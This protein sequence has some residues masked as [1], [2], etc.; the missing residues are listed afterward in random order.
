MKNYNTHN[1]T[2]IITLAILLLV[3]AITSAGGKQSGK[4]TSAHANSTNQIIVKP[5][6]TG[7]LSIAARPTMSTLKS[8][9]ESIQMQFDYRRSTGTGAW[10]LRLPKNM[11]LTAAQAI[12][13]RLATDPSIEYAMADQRMYPMAVP[14]DTSYV[15]QWHY[16]AAAIESGAA[17]LPS[18]WDVTL[19]SNSVVVAV[20]DTGLLP[21]ADID[22]NLLDNTG[23]VTNGYDFVSEDAAGQYYTANDGNGRDADPTDPGDWINAA[24]SAGVDASGGLFAG[25]PQGD[26]TWHGTHVS[27]TIAASSNNNTGVAGIL[28]SGR[29]MPV[30]VLGKC[31]GYSSDIIDGVLWAAGL[32]PADG[33]ADFPAPPLTPAKV[34]NMSF[35]GLSPICPSEWQ[36]LINSVVAAGTTIVVAAGNDGINASGST[37]ANCNNVIAVGAHRR[38]GGQASYSN[39]GSKVD[40]SAPGGD[41]PVNPDGILSLSNFGITNA[42]TDTY[43]YY[44][45]TSMASPHVSGVAGLMLSINSDITP[46]QI[47]SIIKTN[48]RP[49][50]TGTGSDCT[51]A[52]CGDGMLDASL[53]VNAVT[54]TLIADTSDIYFSE[55]WT[56]LSATPR[57]ITFTNTH[58]TTT[59]N[60]GSVSVAGVNAG[61][62][63]LP[64]DACSGQALAAG[65]SCDIDV[66]FSPATSGNHQAMITVSSDAPSNPEIGLNGDAGPTITITATD[67][68]AAE[69]AANTA[70]F[71][72]NSSLTVPAGGLVV[73]YT[74]A[75]TATSGSDYTALSGSATLTAG[76]T[77]TDV[78]LTP[79]DDAT[80]EN[81]ENIT[82]SLSSATSYVIGSPA[83][84]T[85]YLVSDDGPTVTITATDNL[86]A[87][88]GT[89][90]AIFSI[91]SNQ[92]A[93][94]GGLTVN[95]TVSGT[96]VSGSD[97]TPISGSATIPGGAT[98]TSV[99]ITPRNDTIFELTESVDLAISNSTNYMTGSPS[100]ASISIK[101]ND[102]MIPPSSGGGGC[103]IA[104]ASY[105][106]LMAPEINVLRHFR[107]EYLLTNIPG[108]WFVA[109][110]YKLSPPIADELRK[111]PTLRALMRASLAPLV[112]VSNWLEQ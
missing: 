63:L 111:H 8:L 65:A 39:Y 7:R 73:N 9:S 86:A 11:S 6:D 59:Y 109:A 27:G 32:L 30:R 83:N 46:A 5:E 57:T 40:I 24:E 4:L 20:I 79:I 104:T 108:Q 76:T 92:A 37:P 69:A 43:G 81:M 64:S 85:A 106:T 18:A 36:S 49:F 45:G 55:I 70:T 14:N 103:F 54:G 44:S 58:K 107:D 99:I 41:T 60:I 89:D 1:T 80:I 48:S 105:G 101:D 74:V 23:I 10:V 3:P 25:C 91:D 100:F 88:P 61:S 112:A 34:I 96:A 97:Y 26:S 110:Y 31:F 13:D 56:G 90:T 15:S 28:W 50:V 82:I 21:H 22:S 42:T 2:L 38:D 102:T 93:P 84:A 98:S 77:F 12:A 78:I 75:G 16:D 71:R 87:E 35:G 95:Y 51:T 33:T 19:G 66:N 68:N 67:A 47:E 72:I 62:Y 53:A 17:N 94:G 52:L 29:L